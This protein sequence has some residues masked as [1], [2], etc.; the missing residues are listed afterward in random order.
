[1]NRQIRSTRKWG[2]FHVLFC[3]YIERKRKR[4][5]VAR[6]VSRVSPLIYT[7]STQQAAY[8]TRAGR[9]SL[10][11]H[12]FIEGIW[13]RIDGASSSLCW[14]VI[15]EAQHQEEE[16]KKKKNKDKKGYIRHVYH[17]LLRVCPP[18]FFSTTQNTKKGRWH[19]VVFYKKK[20]DIIC[21]L[22][23]S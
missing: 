19:S 13:Q 22:I 16:G 17:A 5:I 20:L 1:M 4:T 8:N 3:I 2:Q 6:L 9:P 10:S 15:D 18:L 11:I 12:I 14:S 21:N 23:I 7:V